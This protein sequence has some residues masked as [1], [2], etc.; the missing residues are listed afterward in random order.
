[1]KIATKVVI[2]LLTGC[3]HSTWSS[4]SDDLLTLTPPKKSIAVAVTPPTQVVK[5]EVPTTSKV[6]VSVSPDSGTKG[7]V[8]KLDYDEDEGLDGL[9]A[10]FSQMAIQGDYLGLGRVNPSKEKYVISMCP[11]NSSGDIYHILCL[12]VLA[13]WSRC[14]PCWPCTTKRVLPP[15]IS[16][17]KTRNAT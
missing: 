12:G 13:E 4:Q 6:V 9:A 5:E 14:L 3:M 2:I 1:M 8:W 16:L 10:L 7:V 17:T 11:I 15:S